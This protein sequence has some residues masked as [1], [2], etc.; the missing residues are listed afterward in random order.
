MLINH[1]CLSQVIYTTFCL[2]FRFSL[3]TFLRLKFETSEQHLSCIFIRLMLGI[4]K[5]IAD[6]RGNK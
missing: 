4:R 3:L 1:N 2:Q 6:K 5:I